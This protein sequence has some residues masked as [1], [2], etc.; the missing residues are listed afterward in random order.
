LLAGPVFSREVVTAPRRARLYIARATYVLG[1]LGLV[2]TARLVLGGSQRELSL[3]DLARFSEILF[4]TLV[5]GQ[6]ALAVFFAALSSASAVAQEKDRKTLILLLLTNLSNVELVLGRLLASLLN[7]VLMLA[8]AAPLFMLLV[9]LGGVGF[10]QVGRVLAVTLTAALAAGSLGSTLAFWREKTFQTLALT[11]LVLVAWLGF[12]EVVGSGVLGQSWGGVAV[13]RI[14]TWLSPWQAVG[15]AM[16]PAETGMLALGPLAGSVLVFLGASLGIALLL[17]AWAILRVRVW[18]PSQEV[19]RREPRES[20]ESVWGEDRP[21]QASSDGVGESVDEPARARSVHAAPGKTRNV[22]NNPVLWREIRTWAYGRRILVI[23][24]GFLLLVAACWIAVDSLADGGKLTR[25]TRVGALPAAAR[26]VVPLMLLGLGLVNA[27]AV[28][29]LTTERDGKALDLLLV[30][31]L[32]P[33]EIVFGKLGGVFY[34]AKDVVLL[35]M[36]LC[37]YVWWVGGLSGENLFYVVAALAV[38]YLFVATVGIHCGM[39]YLNSRTAIAVSLGTLFFLTLGIAACMQIMISFRG[40]FYT[41]IISFLAV[42]L[43]GALGMYVALGSR[44][45][46]SAIALASAA[47]PFASFYAATSFLLDKPLAAFVVVV[48]AYGFTTAAMLVP[49]IDEFDVVTGR[50]TAEE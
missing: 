17:N 49:A 9:L 4:P 40:T 19:R 28:T 6:L 47:C 8:A 50:T 11:A 22:W 34:N 25:R 29:S 1:L 45:P 23:R 30:T 15:A 41:Q 38:M 46:S 7:V 26:P 35:P 37:G 13:S 21:K 3:S 33:K 36:L 10:D 20:Q 27:L 31:D 12:W 43:G 42:I 16:R 24:L 5:Y 48:L 44:N 18:N 39:I 32:S 2:C 14:A